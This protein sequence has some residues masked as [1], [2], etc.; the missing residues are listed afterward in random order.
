MRPQFSPGG[1]R[2][3]DATDE[4]NTAEQSNRARQRKESKIFSMW[5]FFGGLLLLLSLDRVVSLFTLVNTFPIMWIK[6]ECEQSIVNWDLQCAVWTYVMFV[7]QFSFKYYKI[8]K[9][10]ALKECG[11]QEM[12][13]T[14]HHYSSSFFFLWWMCN[15]QCAI[16]PQGT[17]VTSAARTEAIKQ[18]CCPCSC[19]L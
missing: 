2:S 13:A 6:A 16:G 18:N 10:K 9:N 8:K 19:R 14:D 12:L 4:T 17:H 15:A 5:F 11:F 1:S 7:L 3:S